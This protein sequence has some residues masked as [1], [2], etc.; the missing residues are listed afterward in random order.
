MPSLPFS[1]SRIRTGFASEFS[2]LSVE[3]GASFILTAKNFQKCSHL[4][5]IDS[6]FALPAGVRLETAAE[7]DKKKLKFIFGRNKKNLD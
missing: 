5:H 6:L 4:I 2:R 1:S 7:I 3:V